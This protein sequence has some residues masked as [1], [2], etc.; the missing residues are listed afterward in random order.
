M[1]NKSKK[2]KMLLAL[3]TY[4]KKYL[5]KKITDLDESGTRLMINSFLTDVLGYTPIE[6]IKTEYMIRGT[7][8][9]YVIQ[10]KGVRHF[11][12]EVKSFSLQ[13]SGKHLRQALN[14]GANEGIDWILL[15]NGKNFDFYKVIF[16]RPIESR[17]VFSVDLSDK[18]NLKN[19]LELLQYLH[20]DSILHKNLKSLWNK[21][22]ALDPEYVSG[23]LHDSRIANIIRKSLNRKFAAKFS[24]EEIHNSINRVIVEAINLEKIKII[25]TKKDKKTKIPNDQSNTSFTKI[26]E[27][28]TFEPT[29]INK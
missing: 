4:S 2:A 29:P 19:S 22:K 26:N 17:K 8:A 23:L 16:G 7:Y 27:G 15:T 12:I 6:E 25:K 9:D 18:K 13:L 21:T 5:N 14:Y 1:L 20:R 10:I 3:K 11:L 28:I 24:E